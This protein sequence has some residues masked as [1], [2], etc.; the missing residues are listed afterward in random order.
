MNFTVFKEPD[1][2]DQITAVAFEPGCE[3]RKLCGHLPLALKN[4]DNK[5]AK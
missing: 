3:T 5:N 1:L 2:Q 4:K